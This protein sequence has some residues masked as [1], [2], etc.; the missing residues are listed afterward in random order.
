MN[1][2]LGVDFI[3]KV[4]TLTY[5]PQVKQVKIIINTLWLYSEEETFGF[6]W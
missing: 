3:L 2:E 1:P 5:T 4:K 6:L